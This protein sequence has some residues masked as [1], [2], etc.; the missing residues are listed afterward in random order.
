MILRE[1][2]TPSRQIRRILTGM[3]WAEGPLWLPGQNALIVSDIPGNRIVQW[4]P[5]DSVSVFR[6]PANRA[7][8]NALDHDGRL[9]T[10][11]HGTRSVTRTEVDGTITVI[12]DQ[13]RGMRLNSPN[14]LVVCPDGSILFSDPDYALTSKLYTVEGKHEIGANNVYRLDPQTGECEILLGDFDKPNG[15]ALSPDAERLYVADSGRSHREDGPHH[16]RTFAFDASRK[17]I[18]CGPTIMISPGVPD[19]LKVDVLGNLW[20]SAHD[21][22]HCHGPDGSFIGLIPIPEVV[23]NLAFGGPENRTLFIAASTSVYAVDLQVAGA[24]VARR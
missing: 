14:D 20:I 23:A 4:S 24:T 22:V 18:E 2:L 6:E 9:I 16:V 1:L 3:H 5:Q 7:N 10:C 12:V 17:P 15:L 11:E 8:G 13:Y 19:G 21:G